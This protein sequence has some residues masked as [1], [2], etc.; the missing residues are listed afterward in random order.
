MQKYTD[1]LCTTVTNLTTS[2]LQDILTFDG[3]DTM[4]LKDWLSDIETAAEIL[5]ESWA[6]L[7]E[8]KSCGLTHTLIFNHSKPGSAGMTLGIYFI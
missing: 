6:H 5:K 7:A 3:Q 2:L 8:A 4:T 1:T